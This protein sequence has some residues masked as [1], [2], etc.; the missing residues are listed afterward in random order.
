MTQTPK[1]SVIVPAY[2]TAPYISACLD[3]I[4]AQTFTDIE[5]ICINDGSPDDA[6]K[7]FQR[8]ARRDKRIRVMTQKNQGIVY[9]RNNAIAAARGK[10]IFPIDSDDM[11]APNCL[12]TLYKIITTTDY[13]IVS[14]AGIQFGERN[15]MWKLPKICRFNMYG[16][17]NGIH[18]SSLFPRELWKKYGGYCRELNSLCLED[19]DFWL[20]FM[21]DNRR[22]V[23]TEMPLFFYRIKPTDQSRNMA[24]PEYGKIAGQ[25]IRRRHPRVAFYK[26]IIWMQN[27]FQAIRHAIRKKKK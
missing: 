20:C 22:A 12:E 10:Y 16:G 15:R 2:K 5:I 25:I 19:Y 9:A 24:H 3:S 21:D 6:L 23:R 1:I 17:R 4:L 26:K 27:P 13:D 18:N 11:I 14:P 8:Y 7:I